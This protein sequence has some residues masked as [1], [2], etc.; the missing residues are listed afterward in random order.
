M[1]KVVE[2]KPVSARYV[3]KERGGEVSPPF[4]SDAMKAMVIEYREPDPSVPGGWWESRI[5]ASSEE[6]AATLHRELQSVTTRKMWMDIGH[7]AAKTLAV[8]Q[9]NGFLY[10]TMMGERAERLREKGV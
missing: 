3:T 1:H 4:W 7:K 8:M 2:V 9:G 10:R 5:Y 6:H